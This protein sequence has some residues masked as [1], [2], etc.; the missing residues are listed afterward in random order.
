MRRDRDYL[1]F[2]IAL[3][4]NADLRRIVAVIL[5]D[6]CAIVVGEQRDV[7]RSVYLYGRITE[8]ELLSRVI[9][10]WGKLY[11]SPKFSGMVQR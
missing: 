1:S 8:Q 6:E 10:A 9:I 7:V 4:F 2:A 3:A 11:R 5:H